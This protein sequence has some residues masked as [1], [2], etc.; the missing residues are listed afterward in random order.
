M[1]SQVT[2]FDVPRC[3]EWAAAIEADLTR[4]TGTLTE[5]QFHAPSRAGGWSVGFCIEHMV[6]TGR[7]FLP[8]W[9]AALQD[10]AAKKRIGKHPEHYTWWQRR[11]LHLLENPDRLKQKTSPPFE[12]YSRRSIEETIARF[13]AMHQEFRRRITASRGLDISRSRVQSPFV[14]WFRYA[15]GFSFDLALVHERRHI[16]Q[17]WNTTR[18]FNDAL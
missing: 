3:L 18:Q 17:A 5:A 11:I 14:P 8:R 6:L 1:V 15:L 7:A 10:A 2:G 13:L 12:P 9:D 4:L 16:F